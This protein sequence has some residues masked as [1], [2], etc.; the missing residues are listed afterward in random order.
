MTSFSSIAS[1]CNLVGRIAKVCLSLILGVV[2]GVSIIK[3][4]EGGIPILFYVNQGLLHDNKS[5]ISHNFFKC[6]SFGLV[7]KTLL[8]PHLCV[9]M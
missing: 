6:K 4:F 3:Y 9:Q 8:V 7:L 5:N 2:I 1:I